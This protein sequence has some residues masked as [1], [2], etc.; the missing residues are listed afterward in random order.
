MATKALRWFS[1]ISALGIAACFALPAAAQS[2]PAK[3]I[4]IIALSSSGS[5][6]DIVGRLIGG[7]LTEAWGEQVIV[8][9]RPAA[10]GI[11]GTEIASKAPPDGHTLL[12]VTSQA[13][14]VSVMYDKL[15]Y[16]LARDFTPITLVATTPFILAVHPV[17]PA[18]SIKELVALAKRQPGALRYGSGGS[19]SPPHLS[20]EMFKSMTGIDM[21]HVPYKGITPAMVDAV[22][23]HVHMLISVIPAVLPTIKSGKLRPL[24][25]TSAKR[26]PLVPDIPAI[27]E[28]VTGYEFIG[29]YSLF[30][31][32]KTPAPVI[33]KLNA[34][35]VKALQ[36]PEFRERFLSLGAEPRPSTPQ[37]LAGWLRTQTEK[38]RKAVQDS[39]ARRD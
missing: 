23:G 24:G 17:V 4:R 32:T 16:S 12:I 7:K 29:W 33:D 11:V 31:P 22:A 3:P 18:N 30:A 9:P 36:T 21:L 27:A 14:I 1:A 20:T 6:P 38:M 25:V 34:E 15:P 8:D 28:T 35:I 37:E 39:G 13:V 2:Y 19:G 26:T 5:G 10:T